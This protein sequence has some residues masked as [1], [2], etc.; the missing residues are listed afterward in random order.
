M[1]IRLQNLYVDVEVKEKSAINQDYLASRKL[2]NTRMWWVVVKRIFLDSSDVWKAAWLY[3]LVG[4]SSLNVNSYLKEVFI[5]LFFIFFP[6]QIAVE[7]IANIRTVVS[8]VKEKTF[9]DKYA[10]ALSAPYKW[11]TLFSFHGIVNYIFLF[12]TYP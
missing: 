1:E 7:T 12:E 8:L 4:E 10:Q 3:V 6:W 5:K 2:Y 9:F 11:V